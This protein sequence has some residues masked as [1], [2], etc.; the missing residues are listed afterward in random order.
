[1]GKITVKRHG[2]G[3]NHRKNTPKTAPNMAGLDRHA[4]FYAIAKTMPIV[5]TVV[6][7]LS[8]KNMGP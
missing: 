1:M 3:E 5:T 2:F 8:T 4:N 7:F 6:C